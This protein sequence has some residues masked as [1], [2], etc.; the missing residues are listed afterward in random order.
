M[1]FC[2]RKVEGTQVLNRLPCILSEELLINP[3]YFITKSGIDLYSMGIWERD[4]RTFTNPNEQHNE[5]AM[6]VMF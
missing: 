3:N 2:H 1:Y 6:E 4:K 5:K